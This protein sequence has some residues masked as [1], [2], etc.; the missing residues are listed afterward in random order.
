MLTA[1]LMSDIAIRVEDVASFKWQ[2]L[3][4]KC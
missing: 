4:S 1:R 2:V 3:S